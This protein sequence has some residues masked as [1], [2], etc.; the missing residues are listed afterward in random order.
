MLQFLTLDLFVFFVFFEA[1]FI[2]MY[3]LIGLF[4]SG[5][6]RILA[7]YYLLG[8]TL[9][10]SVFMLVGLVMLFTKVKTTNVIGLGEL[11][12]GNGVLSG[13]EGKLL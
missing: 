4:G 13:S 1:L 9:L 8:Y 7:N 12:Q 3:F 11:G 2:P 6:K 10:G 5:A